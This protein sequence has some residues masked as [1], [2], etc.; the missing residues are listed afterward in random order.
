ME[1]AT[2]TSADAQYREW[3]T[4]RDG[5]YTTN[6]GILS[7]V[8]RSSA[9]APQPDLFLYAVIGRFEGYFPGYSSMVA[10]HPNYLTWVVL[11]GHTNNTAGQVTLR[12]ADPRVPPDINFHYFDEGNDSRGD[13]LQAVAAGVGIVRR[14]TVRTEGQRAR[15]R[16]GAA[17][18]RRRRCGAA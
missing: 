9:A 14:I 16:R 8:A 15:R 12:S 13:D 18:R 17:G 11:K 3:A 2:F 7:V 10:T 6:G 1:G 4:K 5:I